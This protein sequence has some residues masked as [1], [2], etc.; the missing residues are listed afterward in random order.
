MDMEHQA[1]A[2][3]PSEK[4]ARPAT[5]LWVVPSDPTPT[6]V[7]AALLWSELCRGLKKIRSFS[8]EGRHVRVVVEQQA[9]AGSRI[10]GGRLRA[11]ELLFQG[12]GQTAIAI[13]LGV[14]PSTI[15]VNLKAAMLSLGLEERVFALPPFL[16][17]LW[18]L[19]A[20]A[21]DLCTF[22]D[23]RQPARQTLLLSRVDL[24]LPASLAP[25]ELEVCRLLLEGRSHRQISL[26]RRTALRTVANQLAAVFTKLRVSGRMELVARLVRE[27]SEAAGIATL[28][29]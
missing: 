22:V 5:L 25:A 23:P 18:H 14:S 8:T 28:C 2:F 20:A 12:M 16:P 24:T 1:A 9:C 26:A 19:A 17:Q 3:P 29:L 21:R 10:G 11:L 6:F 7:P 4:Q 27:S 13:E 15:S